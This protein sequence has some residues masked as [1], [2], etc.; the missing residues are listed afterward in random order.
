MGIISPTDNDTRAHVTRPDDNTGNDDDPTADPNP[1]ALA[2]PAGAT[3][4][5]IC[6]IRLLFH[7]HGRLLNGHGFRGRDRQERCCRDNCGDDRVL[8]K[9]HFQILF[10]M[11]DIR[12]IPCL[13]RRTLISISL[14]DH[15]REFLMSE[16]IGMAPERIFDPVLDI[17]RSHRGATSIKLSMPFT[18]LSL[19]AA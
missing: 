14:L 11:F 15:Q 12:I 9:F 16:P 8:Q 13:S 10:T 6:H 1:P 4:S 7:S 2:K 19:A 17:D 18:A 5:D 3:P